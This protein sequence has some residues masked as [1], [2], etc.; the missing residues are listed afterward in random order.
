MFILCLGGG[1]NPVSQ[2]YFVS[3]RYL[4]QRDFSYRCQTVILSTSII[5]IIHHCLV[6]ITN[7]WLLH[8]ESTYFIR[9]NQK[10]PSPKMEPRKRAQM[11]EIVERGY[12]YKIQWS[13]KCCLFKRHAWYICSDEYALSSS[14]WQLLRWICPW[15]QTPCNWRLQCTYGLCEDCNAHMGFVDKSDGMVNSYGIGE[16]NFFSTF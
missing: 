2:Y 1:T 7:R 14:G 10:P 11:N 4:C 9:F 3:K 5:I 15:C 12:C 16:R 8:C 6:S 13:S